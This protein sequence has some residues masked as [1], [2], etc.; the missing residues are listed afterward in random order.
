MSSVLVGIL[1]AIQ[2]TL[3]GTVY[4]D[5]RVVFFPTTGMRV[6]R[7]TQWELDIHGWIFEDRP[8]RLHVRAVAGVLGLTPADDDRDGHRILRERGRLFFVDSESGVK[9]TIRLGDQRFTLPRSRSNGHFGGSIRITN[10]Q[11]E[12]LADAEGWIAFRAELRPGDSRAFEGRVQLIEPEGVSI[13]SDIDDTLRISR[14]DDRMEMMNRAFVQPFEEVNGMTDALRA[15]AGAD[16]TVFHYVTA[17]PWQMF[18]ALEEYF[19]GIDMPRG[20]FHMNKFRWLDGSLSRMRR[21]TGAYKRAQIQSIL[22]RYPRRRVILIGDSGEQD[23]EIYAGF[24]RQ[25]P[26]RISHILIRDTTGEGADAPRYGEMFATLCNTRVLVFRDPAEIR[27]AVDFLFRS[28]PP[29]SGPDTG[30]AAMTKVQSGHQ[31]LSESMP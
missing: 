31:V 17:A 5:E 21:P 15:W 28:D 9:I 27:T 25:Y 30:L 13:I 23:P 20:S 26:R 29:R 12:A 8:R 22:F 24:A 6:E 14:A 11:A 16:N 2:C 10:A 1:T 3:P 4:S 7:N 19:D 18:P